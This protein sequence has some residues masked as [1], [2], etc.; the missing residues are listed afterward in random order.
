MLYTNC[1]YNRKVSGN[2]EISPDPYS[3]FDFDDGAPIVDVNKYAD[4]IFNRDYSDFNFGDAED[5]VGDD[6]DLMD[7]EFDLDRKI[8]NDKKPLNFE[9]VVAT[10]TFQ[11]TLPDNDD[12]DPE[13]SKKP[14]FEIPVDII[15]DT[16]LSMPL[17]PEM[18]GTID[19][20]VIANTGCTFHSNTYYLSN[21]AFTLPKNVILQKGV[22]GCGGTTLAITNDEDYYISMPFKDLVIEK[23]NLHSECLAIFKDTKPYKIIKY[24]NERRSLNLPVK[25]IGTYDSMGTLNRALSIDYKHEL[26]NLNLLVD[27]YHILRNAYNYR[28]ESITDIL[29]YFKRFKSYSFMSATPIPKKY[30]FRKLQD[31]Q[32]YRV[33]WQGKKQKV[34]VVDCTENKTTLENLQTWMFANNLKGLNSYVYFNS[35]DG[36]R[37]ILENNSNFNVE[38]TKIIY[39]STNDKVLYDCNGEEFR[40]RPLTDIC[41]YT[42]LTASNFEG[43]NINDRS[44]IT[45]VVSTASK[46][47]L[48]YIHPY[49][50]EQILGRNRD[51]QEKVI[52]HFLDLKAPSYYN[53]EDRYNDSVSKILELESQAEILQ[54]IK[55][56]ES[57][58][59][60]FYNT[61]GDVDRKIASVD[62]RNFLITVNGYE[63]VIQEN[64]NYYIDSLYWE[65]ARLVREY[66]S[67]GFEVEV[68][69]GQEMELNEKNSKQKRIGLVRQ[70]QNLLALHGKNYKVMAWKRFF[71]KY[72]V[73]A[74][75]IDKGYKTL[76]QIVD[77]NKSMKYWRRF[78]NDRIFSGSIFTRIVNDLKAEQK[79][80]IGKKIHYQVW[81]KIID[82]VFKGIVRTGKYGMNSCGDVVVFKDAFIIKE[83]LEPDILKDEYLLQVDAVEVSGYSPLYDKDFDYSRFKAINRYLDV[84][85]TTVRV[86]GS[87]EYA[88]LIKGFRNKAV[89]E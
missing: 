88:Y 4:F 76:E 89:N 73:I 70:I 11:N 19:N 16:Y 42:F 17:V 31:I 75:I 79:I 45:A 74:E 83:G 39:S 71:S 2:C 5:K 87:S 67:L 47:L 7:I 32:E 23:A 72:P 1:I 62:E 59:R 9:K 55:D 41:K 21:N 52:Y 26:D 20:I 65:Q 61:I 25:I 18:S 82:D 12:D 53:V 69:E 30:L 8:Y 37:N 44:S 57:R 22:T 68:L 36:I 64:W 80:S 3:D 78:L 60:Y 29:I 84:K 81:N 24:I 10:Q 66:E 6:I 14:V 28:D 86:N 56:A 43:K 58:E 46:Q 51:L 34:I 77:D 85:N 48:T 35:L 50:V 63:R 13:P 27:E 54:N 15:G 38:N 40:R 33:E 49:T